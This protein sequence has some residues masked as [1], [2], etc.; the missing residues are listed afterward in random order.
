MAQQVANAANAFQLE[1]TGHA[2]SAVTVVLN[3]DTLVITLQGVLSPAEKALAAN[4][5]GAA[6]VQEFHRELFRNSAEFLKREISRITGV[7]VREAAADV[8]PSAG[9]AVQVFTTGTMVQV[10]LLAE[11]IL[12]SAWNENATIKPAPDTSK[13]TH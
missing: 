13:G 4:P 9:T 6:K 10:F 1:R 5:D 11:G 7:K 8:E 3:E 2:P 12:A